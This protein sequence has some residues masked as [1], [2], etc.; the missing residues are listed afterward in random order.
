M[1]ELYVNLEQTDVEKPVAVPHKIQHANALL[2]MN[3]SCWIL[4]DENFGWNGTDIVKKV[5]K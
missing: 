4:K 1:K 2:K 3:K 5:K